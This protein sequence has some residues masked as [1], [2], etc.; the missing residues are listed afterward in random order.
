MGTLRQKNRSVIS[1]A[2]SEFEKF[3]EKYI[4]EGMV[5][6]AKAGLDYLVEVHKAHAMF[7]YHPDEDNTMAYA[8][9]HNGSII[10][11]DAHN[12]GDSDD[13]PGTAQATAER[14]LSDT[15]GWV[16]LI[17]SEMEGYYRFDLEEDF[18]FDVSFNAQSEFYSYFKPVR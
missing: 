11:S 9:A 15:S 7:M 10:A 12:G 8:V 4:R 18:F 6:L 2:F 14:L 13:M 5:R 16:V 17:L 3:E 1:K